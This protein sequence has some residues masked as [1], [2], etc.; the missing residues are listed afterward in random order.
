MEKASAFLLLASHIFVS[1]SAIDSDYALR[2][3]DEEGLLSIHNILESQRVLALLL[4]VEG[5]EDDEET[6]VLESH[7]KGRDL[8][9]RDKSV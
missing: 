3:C 7:V 8:R 9:L 6:E 2:N 1:V 5:E 4:D